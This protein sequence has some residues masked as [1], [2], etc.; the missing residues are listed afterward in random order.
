MPVN[1][2]SMFDTLLTALLLGVA[3][4]VVWQLITL[5]FTY[6]EL[7]SLVETRVAQ[8]IQRVFIPCTVEQHDDVLYL[9]REDNQEFVVQGRTRE[10]IISALRTR[11]GDQRRLVI[12]CD[13]DA[14]LAKLGIDTDDEATVEVKSQ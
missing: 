13:D 6:R 14:I 4:Q 2:E 3:A 9:F 10:E 1:P 12:S 7:N 11:F 8:E 5:Y